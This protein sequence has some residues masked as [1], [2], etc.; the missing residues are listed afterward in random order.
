MPHT[1]PRQAEAHLQTEAERVAGYLNVNTHP[2]L[3]RVVEKT[4]LHRMQARLIHK[5]GSG[6]KM[7]LHH[8]KVQPHCT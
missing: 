3:I 6:L 2:K 4:V 1:M 8:N 7:L 5:D